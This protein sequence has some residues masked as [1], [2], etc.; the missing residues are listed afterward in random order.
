MTEAEWLAATDP[1]AMLG[2]LRGEPSYQTVET[3]GSFFGAVEWFPE[4]LLSARRV[5]LFAVACCRPLEA[6]VTPDRFEPLIA[7]REAEGH[8]YWERP[9]AFDPSAVWL[10]LA[11]AEAVAE[12]VAGPDEHEQA[13]ETVATAIEVSEMAAGGRAD[14][15]D[16]GFEVTWLATEAIG[17]CL[18]RA[19]EEVEQVTNWVS[20][21]V[22][23]GSREG[24]APADAEDR[25]K[26]A[27]ADLLRDIAGSPCRPV[28]LDP[29]W[30]TSTVVALAHGIYADR[31][32]DRMPILADA[33]QDAGCDNEDVLDHCRGPGPHARGCWV[34]DLVLGKA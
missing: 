9:A 21:A 15:V 14:E 6:W 22:A 20:R 32:F 28:G 25:A 30:L 33:L 34:V 10:A 8:G 11:T 3:R 12:G 2:F 19:T 18:R 4:R 29:A 16:R 26:A 24:G 23:A 1:K 17:C 5:R 27:M 13:V 31:A 7:W